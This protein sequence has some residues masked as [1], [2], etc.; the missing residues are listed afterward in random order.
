M[1]CR[2]SL[3]NS[4]KRSAGILIQIDGLVWGS[5]AKLTVLSSDS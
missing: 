3:S 1:N 4:A 5:I 2:I